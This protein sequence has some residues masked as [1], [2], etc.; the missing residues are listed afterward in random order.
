[1]NICFNNYPLGKII[2]SRLRHVPDEAYMR[3]KPLLRSLLA[4][5]STCGQVRAD[6]SFVC[7]NATGLW[8]RCNHAHSPE[9]AQLLHRN[10]TV[11]Q[12]ASGIC[13]RG[14]SVRR[15]C[16]A[17]KEERPRVAVGRKGNASLISSPQN[18]P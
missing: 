9:P 18:A 5:D 17:R 2:Q 12:R 7:F 16:K 6:K 4:L 14:L 1:M 8:A 15:R 10:A 11:S 13:S 3:L